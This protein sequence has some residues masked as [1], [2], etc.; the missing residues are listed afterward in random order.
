PGLEQEI[1]GETPKRWRLPPRTLNSLI[2][3]EATELAALENSI[4]G[5]AR[6]GLQHLAENLE[7]LRDKVRAIAN[8]PSL[9]TAE[10]DL[11]ALSEAQGIAARPG[12][13]PRIERKIMERLREAILGCYRVRLH[14]KSRGTGM[15][16]R[17]LVCPY[18]FLY[19]N[20]HY[21]AA[22]SLNR[23]VLDYRLFSLSNISRVEMTE[24]QFE[25]RPDFSMEKYLERSFGVF[26]EEPFEVAWK[27]SPEVAS[28]AKE[29][30]FHP[31]QRV[32]DQPDGSVVVEFIAGGEL[33]MCWHLFS[34][35][36]M[37]EVLKPKRLKRR[38][39]QL[40]ES[41]KCHQ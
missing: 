15:I 38:F 6:Q 4:E 36:P 32:I 11:E 34:W 8:P 25:R 23:M 29:Y 16:S 40:L 17:Q 7:S 19:G 20:R 13:R 37:V 22:Y 21:L 9:R 35:G 3:I 31:S 1:P 30:S 27:F 14:Y 2:T 39:N 28:D 24:V 12:P 41:Y 18:G 26:Q 33:E 10:P 5:A